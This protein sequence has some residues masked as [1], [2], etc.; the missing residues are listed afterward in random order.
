MVLPFATM[1][2]N[3]TTYMNI[4]FEK[5]TFFSYNIRQVNRAF[6]TNFDKFLLCN[7]F[8][9]QLNTLSIFTTINL[10]TKSMY[11]FLFPIHFSYILR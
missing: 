2:R 6:P 7:Y 11:V 3:S 1:L 9:I 8:L 4:P 10:I 5:F